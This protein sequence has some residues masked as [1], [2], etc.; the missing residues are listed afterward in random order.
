MVLAELNDDSP[1]ALQGVR[2]LARYKGGEDKVRSLPC[3]K[4]GSVWRTVITRFR[5]CVRLVVEFSVQ[6]G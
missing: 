1:T 6:H 2:L 5:V 4:V 3:R